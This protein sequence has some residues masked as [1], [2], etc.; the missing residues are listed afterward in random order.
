MK[1]RLVEE[2]EF[3]G[4]NRKKDSLKQRDG[5]KEAASSCVA[6]PKRKC[7]DLHTKTIELSKK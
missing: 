2:K 1:F 3:F 5:A 4:R 7:T 6:S